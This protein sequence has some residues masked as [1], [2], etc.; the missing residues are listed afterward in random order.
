MLLRLCAW[1][2]ELAQLS[3]RKQSGPL[4]ALAAAYA[5]AGRFEDAIK[6]GEEAF[7][8]AKAA[9]ENDFADSIRARIDLYKKGSPFRLPQ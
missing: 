9:G 6:T 8:I 7:S 4:D 3:G 1:R 5:N 2:S